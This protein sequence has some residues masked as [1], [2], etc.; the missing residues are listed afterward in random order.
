MFGMKSKLIALLVC[1]L[2]LTSFGSVMAQDTLPAV[3]LVMWTTERD[4]PI[5]DAYQ[6]LFDTWAEQN[7]PGS[8]IEITYVETEEMRNQLLTAGLAGTGLP[9]LFLGPN[10]PIGVFVDAGI[11]QPVD[12]LVDTSVFSAGS[13]EAATLDGTL[14]GIPMNAGNHLML[15]YNK[16]LVPEAPQ[17]WAELIEVANQVETDNPDVQGFAYNLNE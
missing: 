17:T 12:D 9:D 1:M 16:D 10:D 6:S 3:D 4:Q 8:T 15:L 14:Y 2:V 11:L 7:A 5:I 13:L